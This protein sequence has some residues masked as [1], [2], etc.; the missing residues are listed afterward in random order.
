V[1]RGSISTGNGNDTINVTNFSNVNDGPVNNT[2]RINTGG[3][4]DTIDL[5]G[6]S[7]HSTSE[8]CSSLGAVTI[9]LNAANSDN[10]DR[11][12]WSVGHA[13]GDLVRGF[14]GGGAAA[15][16][17]LR[18]EGFGPGASLTHV[19]ARLWTVTYNGSASSESFTLQN[20][21]GGAITTLN[22]NDFLFALASAARPWE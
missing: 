9:R 8:I 6:F 14:D 20:A 10:V 2:L 18:F 21:A 5:N 16:D 17:Q 19:G 1:K 22:P 12:I 7:N 15:L 13:V 4:I 3:G 11:I